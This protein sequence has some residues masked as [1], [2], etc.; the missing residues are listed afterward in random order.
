MTLDSKMKLAK[1]YWFECGNRY[2]SSRGS[3]AEDTADNLLRYGSQTW[4]SETWIDFLM[5]SEQVL[6]DQEC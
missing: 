5:L 6:G 1:D 4:F 2:H 3:F